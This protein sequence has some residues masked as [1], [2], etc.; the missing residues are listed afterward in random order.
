[1]TIDGL[2]FGQPH[3]AE[4]RASQETDQQSPRHA[5][6]AVNCKNIERVV[7]AADAFYEIHR[8][9]ADDAASQPQDYSA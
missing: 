7:E 6:N 4:R 2:S 5:S 9:I 3:A 8:D 1:M